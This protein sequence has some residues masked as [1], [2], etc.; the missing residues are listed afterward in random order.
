[1]EELI[2]L[3]AEALHQLICIKSLLIVIAAATV[4]RWLSD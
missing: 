1:M 3:I 4:L 2:E